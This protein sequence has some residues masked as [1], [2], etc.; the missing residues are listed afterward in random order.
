M[1]TLQI[2]AIYGIITGAILSACAWLMG[3]VVMLGLLHDARREEKI[4]A[5]QAIL[6]TIFLV[7][8]W[9]F[10]AGMILSRLEIQREHQE[11]GAD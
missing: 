6:W 7:P 3:Y 9:P 10:V 8:A 1:T 4:T 11:T 2:I 5:R